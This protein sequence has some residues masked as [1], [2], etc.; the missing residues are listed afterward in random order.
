LRNWTA[1]IT[2]AHTRKID[3][4]IS[5][6]DRF[7]SEHCCRIAPAIA[8]TIEMPVMKPSSKRIEKRA[9]LG[10]FRMVSGIAAIIL[11]KTRGPELPPF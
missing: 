6:R 8:A 10:S 4:K 11:D 9:S 2:T 5:S 3:Q 7:A 1:V